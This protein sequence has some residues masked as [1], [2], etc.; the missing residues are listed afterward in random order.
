[1]SP[2]P[3]VVSPSGM[4]SLCLREQRASVLSPWLLGGVLSE[5]CVVF[6]AYRVV[7]HHL[8]SLLGTGAHP[9]RPAWRALRLMC[10][11]PRGPW[12]VWPCGVLG[13]IFCL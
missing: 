7:V 1:M 12:G 4:S 11:E 13:Q 3:P 5:G 2:P 8:K 6:P 10:L 9:P